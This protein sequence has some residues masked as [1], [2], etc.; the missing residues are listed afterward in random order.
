M[1]V[2]PRR[3]LLAAVVLALLG[4]PL[5]ALAGGRLHAR[6]ALRASLAGAPPPPPPLTA[7]A[8]ALEPGGE[9]AARHH[10]QPGAAARAHDPPHELGAPARRRGRTR[11]Q[12][13]L[14]RA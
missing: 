2:P 1:A 3:L 6:H 7:A 10:H 4:A 12:P 8:A 9:A 11:S 5:L 13:A 14:M